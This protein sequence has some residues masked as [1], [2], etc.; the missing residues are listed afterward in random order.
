MTPKTSSQRWR[1]RR[2]LYRSTNP[3]K[4]PSNAHQEE[5]SP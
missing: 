5:A 1:E 2:A 3:I 4:C